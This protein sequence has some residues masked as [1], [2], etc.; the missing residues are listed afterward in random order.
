MDVVKVLGKMEELGM[1][2][3]NRIIGNYMQIYCPI[4]NDGRERKPSCGVLLH[5]EVRN[6]Q[7]YLKKNLGCDIWF[8][9]FII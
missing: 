9:C 2:R 8:S 6:G 7:R 4:H 5:D 1:I 3:T